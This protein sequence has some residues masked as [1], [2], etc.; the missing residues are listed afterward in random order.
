MNLPTVIVSGIYMIP[1]VIFP[2]LNVLT[3]RVINIRISILVYYIN[4]LVSNNKELIKLTYSSLYIL[5]HTL[6]VNSYIL[7]D[8]EGRWCIGSI[9]DCESV[10]HPFNSVTTLNL[11]NV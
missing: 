10:G 9:A 11:T 3:M 6:R 1:S 5:I 8:S 2:S 7:P 4:I